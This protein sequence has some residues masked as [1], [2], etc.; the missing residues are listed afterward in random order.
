M[1]VLR[2]RNEMRNGK[3]IFDLPLRVTFYARVSTDKDEQINSLENQVQYYTEL[4]Q[5]K[6]NWTFVPGYID[7]GIS[8]TST[9]KR[10]SFLRMITDAKAGRFDFII[11]KEIS[12]FSRSTLD[13]IKYTQELLEHD[14]GVLFQNDNINTLDSD[15]EFRLVVMAGVAQDEVRKLSERLKFGFRQA[16]K[17]GHVLGNDKLWGY[18][19]KDCVLTINEAEAQVVRRIFDLYANQQMGIRRISQKLLDE[20]FTSRKGN[21]F[22]VLTI[23]HILC[24]PKYKGW[25]CANK[26]QTVDYRSKRKIFLDESEWVMYPDPSVPAIVSEELWDRAN[27]LYKRRSQQMMSHQSGAEFHNHYPYSGKIICEEHGTSFHRQVLKSAKGGKEVWQCRVYRNRGRAA[28]SAPQLYTA[29][30]DR[31]M[32][33]IFNQLARNKQAII[34][35]VLAV[36][37]AVP[38]EHDYTQD[39][40]R[41]EKDLSALHTKKDR[42]LEMSIEGVVSMSEFKQRNDGFNEQ[43]RVLE[44]KRAALQAEAEKGRRTEAQLEEIRSAL[45]E[46]LSFR[47]GVNSPLVTTIL[48]K[49]VVKKGSTREVLRL[50][51]FPKF[52]GPWKAVFDREKSSFRCTPF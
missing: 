50:D 15:S 36:L 12:R 4:V 51:I 5:S 28:C 17:N 8:G 41:I 10:D 16:I 30:L 6:P 45:E 43:V 19:K 1:N 3:T 21:A 23:R 29:E 20:G 48:D 49:I 44:E 39:L 27:A 42:L 24:N 38:D 37:Q 34:D 31:I 52:G 33:G 9:K 26:S 35:A 40:R 2:I 25:Y 47:N 22:N 11:T 18:D 14:V 7:E 32:A 13:S 46:E